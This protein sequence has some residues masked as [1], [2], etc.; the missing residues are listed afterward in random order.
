[1][2]IVYMREYVYTHDMEKL[3]Q[4][5]RT[6]PQ[7]SVMSAWSMLASPQVLKWWDKEE[8]QNAQQKQCYDQY[9]SMATILLGT[10]S[11][12]LQNPLQITGQQL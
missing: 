7:V 10:N 8:V 11:Y 12:H 2:Y 3:A 1:M 5:T 6:I 4:I 9:T